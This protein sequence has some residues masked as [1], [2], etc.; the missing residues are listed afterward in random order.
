M[1]KSYKDALIEVIMSCDNNPY[2]LVTL[3]KLKTMYVKIIHDDLL[4]SCGKPISKLSDD[5]LE[6]AIEREYD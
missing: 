1:K 5:D 3:Q 6:H 4:L 2:P